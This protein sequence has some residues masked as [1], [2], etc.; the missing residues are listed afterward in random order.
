MRL[1]RF[2]RR[3]VIVVDELNHPVPFVDPTGYGQ[4]LDPVSGPAGCDDL[5]LPGGGIDLDDVY[6]TCGE[7]AW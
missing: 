7:L 4:G 3:T 5:T 6:D 2:R 1:I